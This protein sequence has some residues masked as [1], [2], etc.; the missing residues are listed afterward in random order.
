MSPFSNNGPPTS[1]PNQKHKNTNLS[2]EITSVVQTSFSDFRKRSFA[3]F[4]LYLDVHIL[5]NK[6]NLEKMSPT[7]HASQLTIITKKRKRKKTRQGL[8]NRVSELTAALLSAI[9]L[10]GGIIISQL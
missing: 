6:L 9:M 5:P 1:E 2:R 7:F 10:G 4:S 3:G 8:P